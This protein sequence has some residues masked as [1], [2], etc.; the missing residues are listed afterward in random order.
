MTR[1]F[2]L[3]MA[4]AVSSC[5]TPHKPDCAP[6]PLMQQSETLKDY[7]LRIITLYDECSKS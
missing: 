3:I 4:C 6:L 7:T 1:I 2:I 5:A